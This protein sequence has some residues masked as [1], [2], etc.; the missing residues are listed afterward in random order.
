MS[1]VRSVAYLD[2]AGCAVTSDLETPIACFE[3]HEGAIRAALQIATS[4][5]SW[6]LMAAR[7]SCVLETA[8]T[9]LP[10][11][12]GDICALP[13]GMAALLHGGARGQWLALRCVGRELRFDYREHLSLVR[14]ALELAES[15]RAPATA[16]TL[17]Q[18]A[19]L[20]ARLQR[21]LKRNQWK[22]LPVGTTLSTERVVP[23]HPAGRRHGSAHR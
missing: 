23:Y 3:L 11:E 13:P 17:G 18:R 8:E 1:A 20:T 7:P 5:S 10:L 4:Y 21:E 19:R 15:A 16:F 2:R 22:T 14:V 6:L 9:T 12:A